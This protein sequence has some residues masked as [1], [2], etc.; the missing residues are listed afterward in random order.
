MEGAVQGYVLRAALEYISVC[1]GILLSSRAD[2]GSAAAR[3]R[4]ECGEDRTE[5]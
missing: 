4:E 5:F 2:A 1:G 3:L